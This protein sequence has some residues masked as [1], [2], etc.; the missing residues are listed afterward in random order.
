[1]NRIFCLFFQ[2]TCNSLHLTLWHLLKGCRSLAFM[3]LVNILNIF[4]LFPFYICNTKLQIIS[5]LSIHFSSLLPIWFFFKSLIA[6]V[7]KTF[8]FLFL[9]H[10]YFWSLFNIFLISNLVFSS[11]N[12]LTVKNWKKSLRINVQ[13]RSVWIS[14]LNI[15]GI[16]VQCCIRKYGIVYCTSKGHCKIESLKHCSNKNN[17]EWDQQS[18]TTLGNHNDSFVHCHI[19]ILYPY[20][21]GKKFR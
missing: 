7:L 12:K 17:K 8:S 2:L 1:M 6:A 9:S 18:W 16:W 11:L 14:L 21:K 19:F 20:L 10:Q 4:H 5:C 13:V 3:F 15:K